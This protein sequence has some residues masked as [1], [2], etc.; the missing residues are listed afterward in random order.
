MLLCP[1]MY[2]TCRILCVFSQFII[3]L[4]R[5]CRLSC[6]SG[7]ILFACLITLHIISLDF[8]VG[9]RYVLCWFLFS[10]NRPLVSSIYV[11]SCNIC[12]A[13]NFNVLA[14]L[15]LRDGIYMF[16]LLKLTCMVSS[17]AISPLSRHW[18]I[19]NPNITAFLSCRS[20][21][22][23]VLCLQPGILIKFWYIL[24]SCPADSIFTSTEFSMA[25][26]HPAS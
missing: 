26:P 25:A 1:A 5:I 16:A 13:C 10:I 9:K 15:L 4:V 18:Y 22:F 12:M 23:S 17:L 19:N 11:L 21:S 3:T 2:C 24:S 14:L 7:F 6:N 20:F 8:F